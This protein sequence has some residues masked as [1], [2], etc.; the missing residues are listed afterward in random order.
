MATERDN[1]YAGFNFLVDL[2]DGTDPSSPLAGF[3]EVS[4]LGMELSVIEYRNGNDRMNV[5]RKLP[6]LTKTGLVRLRRGVVGTTAL[7][8]WLQAAAA[9]KQAYRT[10]T[11]RMQNESREDDVLTWKLINALPVRY[12]APTLSAV[13]TA[14]SIEELVFTCT[15]VEVA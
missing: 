11:I 1:P 7:F 12:S 13:S 14:V 4:G 3:M 6:G 15:S 10:V 5:P 2:G 8:D 9:G